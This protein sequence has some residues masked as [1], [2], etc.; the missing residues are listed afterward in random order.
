MLKNLNLAIYTVLEIWIKV[1]YHLL[2]YNKNIKITRSYKKIM[3]ALQ[4]VAEDEG[5]YFKNQSPSYTV[6]PEKITF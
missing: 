4:S 6:L 3:E 2:I 1:W 5:A